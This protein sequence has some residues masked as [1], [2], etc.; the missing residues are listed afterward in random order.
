MG[1]RL[2]KRFVDGA[3]PSKK[4]QFFWDRDLKGF[5]LKVSPTGLKTYVVQYR[6]KGGRRGRVRRLSIGRH[7]SPWAPD[8]A[9]AEA[10]RVLGEVARGGDPMIERQERRKDLTVSE[11]CDLYLAEGTSTKKASTLATDNGR[12]ER[13]I[14]P[15]LGDI[16]VSDVNSSHVNTLLKSVAQGKIPTDGIGSVA[17]R[18]GG[19]GTASRTVGLLGGIFS[20]AVELGYRTDNPVH[21]V[22]R[23]PDK[24]NQR[25]LTQA[26]LVRLFRLMDEMQ[27]EGAS[28]K[29]IWIIKILALSGARRGEIVQLK[30]SEVSFNQSSL[31][32]EDSKTGQKTTPVSTAVITLLEEVWSE[33][34]RK[35]SFVF[36]NAS[37]NSAYVG[38]PKVWTE[39]RR[40]FG[41]DK[42]RLHDLRH[43]FASLAVAG[44]AS[45]PMIGALLGHKDATTTQ[46]YAHLTDDP[47]RSI[48]EEISAKLTAG[49]QEEW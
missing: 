31:H 46:Q 16:L 47:L 32:F 6:S 30:W 18:L 8:E 21:G 10:M 49:M 26:E 17:G 33:R 9:R 20:F 43:T 14:K 1:D 7:G 2:S 11:L 48:S 25:F 28:R 24:K 13:H 5:G 22:K 44:G 41:D 39:L 12:I 15:I 40:R 45:L 23:F 3:K 37:G 36:P 34:D 35:S 29:A 27:M 38:T 4:V 42:L 19:K